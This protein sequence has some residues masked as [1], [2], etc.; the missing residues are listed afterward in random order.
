[1]KGRQS[2]KV[3]KGQKELAILIFGH[4]QIDGI[5]KVFKKFE[6]FRGII[7]SFRHILVAM[8]GALSRVRK[9][10]FDPEQSFAILLTPSIHP[11]KA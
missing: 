7:Q 10:R 9:L 8:R 5:L 11:A 4:P 6:S 1:M 2:R 3:L